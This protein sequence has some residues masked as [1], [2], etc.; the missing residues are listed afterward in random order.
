MPGRRWSIIYL[1]INHLIPVW[2]FQVMK[3]HLHVKIMDELINS[4]KHGKL[5]AHKTI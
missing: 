4:N 2:T 3:L 5:L 1:K